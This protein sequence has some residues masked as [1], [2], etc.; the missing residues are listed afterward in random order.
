MARRTAEY[1]RARQISTASTPKT[2]MWPALRMTK[3]RSDAWATRR[4]GVAEKAKITAAQMRT[5]SQRAV[6]A[7]REV[8]LKVIEPIVPSERGAAERDAF[9]RPCWP[10]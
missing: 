5:G 4:F 8:A 9:G 1:A 7:R 2:N 10:D 6:W 3:S